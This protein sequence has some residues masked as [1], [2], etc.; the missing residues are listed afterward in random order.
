MWTSFWSR[1]FHEMVVFFLTKSSLTSYQELF[2]KITLLASSRPE[3]W[4]RKVQ[5]TFSV[6]WYWIRFGLE[7][8]D[9]HCSNFSG[10]LTKIHFWRSIILQFLRLLFSVAEQD[11]TL[12]KS[13]ICF[14]CVDGNAYA[15]E[16]LTKLFCFLK[17]SLL[18]KRQEYTI[19]WQIGNDLK[20][21][22]KGIS[23]F[24]RF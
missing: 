20:E 22:V 5:R 1:A 21:R 10:Y 2:C 24:D 11:A 13:W 6:P 9:W 12:S 8:F 17:Q 3:R 16:K 4:P 18:E 19:P 15:D 23:S 14:R 7:K